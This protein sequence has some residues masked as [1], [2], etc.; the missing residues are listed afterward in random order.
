MSFKNGLSNNS[1]KLDDFLAEINRMQTSLIWSKEDLVQLFN[2]II[3]GF[4]HIET[5]VYLDSKM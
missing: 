3:P 1:D 4:N 2:D 5:G